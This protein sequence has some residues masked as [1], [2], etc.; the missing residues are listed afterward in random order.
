[1]RRFRVLVFTCLMC[2]G[3]A[4]PSTQGADLLK[5]LPLRFEESR[6]ASAKYVAHGAGFNLYLGQ[7]ESWLEWRDA[8]GKRTGRVRTVLANAKNGAG[9]EPGDRLP[10][11]ANYFIGSIENWRTDVTGY[12]S[13]RYR[14]VY[15]GIDLVFHGEAG[16]LEYDFVLAP[17][18]DPGAIRF[19]VTGQH[20]L[21]IDGNGDLIVSTDVGEIRWKRPG[22]YQETSSN[23]TGG[24]GKTPVRGSFA[25]V[26]KHTVA[27]RLGAY[28]RDR[29]LTIDPT[30]APPANTSTL[31]YSTF[32]GGAG[33][34]FARGIGLDSAGNVYIAGGTTTTNLPTVSTFQPNFGGQTANAAS[35]DAFIAKFS[36]SGALLYLTYLGGSADDTAM[37]LAVDATGNAYVTGFTTSSN[38]PTAGTPYQS[39]FGG[40]GGGTVMRTGD[41]FVA[42]IA[43]A[44]NKLIYSTYL[45]GSQDDFGLAIAIDGTGAVYVTGGTMSPNFPVSSTAYLKTFQGGGGQQSTYT[46]GIPLIDSGDAFVAKLDAT[47]ANLL[48]STYLGGSRDDVGSTIAL[49]ASDNVYVGGFTLSGNFPTTAGAYQR[50]FG[51]ADPNDLYFQTGDGF[52]AKLKPDGSGLIYSTYFGGAGDDYVQ[53]IAVDAAGDAYF[54]GRSGSSALTTTAGV[55][56]PAFG[57]PLVLPNGTENLVGDAVVGE[58]NPAG[59]AMVYLTWLGGSGNDAGASIAIDAAGNAYVAG[60]SDS[61]NFPVSSSAFQSTMQGDGG[62]V[63]YENFGDAFLSV[64]SPNGAKLLY[65][66]YMGGANDDL[67]LG[68]ALDKAGNIYFGGNTYSS[69]FPTT[70]GAFQKTYGGQQMVYTF[71]WGDAFYAVFSAIPSSPEIAG[72]ANAES[73]AT[74]IAANTWTAIYGTDMSATTRE[75]AGSDFNG[76]QMPTALSGVSVTMNGE[77]TYLYYISGTQLGVLTPPDLVAGPVQVV[78]TNNSVVSNTFTVQAQTIAP[79]FFVYSGTSYV[80]ATHV[81]GQLVGPTTLYPG[82]TTPATTGETLV[83]YV[84]GCGNTSVPFVKGSDMQSG[85]LV[86][87]PVVKIG[88]ITA[89]VGFAGAVSAG[90]YQVNVIVPA[91]LK[92]GDNSITASLGGSSTQAGVLVTIQP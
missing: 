22:I 18:A 51:G 69:N 39:K 26:G 16:R 44:G 20:R 40:Y 25:L 56:Q 85:D 82:S 46:Y 61:T 34:E 72:V 52:I 28:D 67:A 15:A 37:A 24:T 86:P 13:I 60:F 17:H 27:F 47:G 79:A 53:S 19:E 74:I 62:S 64:V 77:K 23:T 33:N 32:L 59:S 21:A 30:L 2:G 9:P 43:P 92:A 36:P 31:T 48:F 45:G 57:G 90:L 1:M 49:D 54:T 55:F 87:L 88:G 81:H 63:L 29:T 4:R 70:S 3:L 6:E 78:V 73:G 75:W 8:S 38:F 76:N 11:A 71:P 35:G 42:K 12:E 50:Q 41:A 58:L 89:T 7:R 5:K 68:L 83:L 80:A 14:R 91:G 65:S 10:G 66:T 84:N